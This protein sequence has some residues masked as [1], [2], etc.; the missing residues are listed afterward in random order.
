MFWV[1]MGT[2]R[3]LLHSHTVIHVDCQSQPSVAVEAVN[4]E[5]FLPGSPSSGFCVTQRQLTQLRQT[6]GP[7]YQD[8]HRAAV[9]RE[10]AIARASGKAN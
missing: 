8:R 4:N 1:S 7:R 10:Y 6:D 5:I 2:V 9:A 3:A